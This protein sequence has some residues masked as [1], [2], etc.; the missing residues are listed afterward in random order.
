MVPES[1]R[2]CTQSLDGGTTIRNLARDEVDTSLVRFTEDLTR[3]N[4]KFLYESLSLLTRREAFA[5][6]GI[7]RKCGNFALILR[8]QEDLRHGDF[9]MNK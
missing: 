3:I 2:V 7:F 1:P 5:L 9:Q 8:A 6:E 4:R